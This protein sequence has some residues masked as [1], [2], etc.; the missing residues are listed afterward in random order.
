M[1]CLNKNGLPNKKSTAY[2]PD[3]EIAEVSRKDEE[4]LSELKEEFSER[5]SIKL[6]V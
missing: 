1:N 3:Y 4:I 5:A 6:D 2:L